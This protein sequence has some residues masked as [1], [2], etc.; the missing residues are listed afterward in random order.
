M[1]DMVF[2]NFIKKIKN[3]KYFYK[4]IDYYTK[5]IEN[6]E[7]FKSEYDKKRRVFS[8]FPVNI[9]DMNEKFLNFI[10]EYSY[11]HPGSPVTINTKNGDC[12][13]SVRV[14]VDDEFII[15]EKQILGEKI[16]K[17]NEPSETEPIYINPLKDSKVNVDFACF[18]KSFREYSKNYSKQIELELELEEKRK[19]EKIYSSLEMDI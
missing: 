11:V 14:P 18:I 1:D 19:A 2:K 7:I 10:Y 4:K 15:N 16:T 3:R 8:I 9:N 17:N 12:F 5:L 13:C 6:K